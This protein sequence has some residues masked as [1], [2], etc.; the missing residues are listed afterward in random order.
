MTHGREGTFDDVGCAQMFAVLGG[1]VVKGEQR[2]AILNQALDRFVV[3]DSPAFDDG[4]ECSE[5]ILLGLGHP[6]LLQRPLG[7]RLQAL[8]ATCC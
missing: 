8:T 7:F 2:V 5:R 4:I 6:D 1:K 3:F